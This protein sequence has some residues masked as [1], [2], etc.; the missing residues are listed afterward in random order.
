MKTQE[1]DNSLNLAATSP[2]SLKQRLENHPR[3]TISKKLAAFLIMLST[4]EQYVLYSHWFFLAYCFVAS[5][6]IALSQIILI[7]VLVHWFATLIAGN[8]TS[9]SSPCSM[10]IFNQTM[11]PKKI[12]IPI[13]TWIF[14][15]MIAALIGLEFLKSLSE[16]LKTSLYLTLPFALFS[17]FRWNHQSEG[18]KLRRIRLYLFAL[19]TSLCLA[20]LHSVFSA[21]VGSELPPKI[22]GPVTESGQLVLIIPCLVSLLFLPYERKHEPNT[23]KTIL[24]VYTLFAVCFVSCLL[25][26]WPQI[27]FSAEA[28]SL[29]LATSLLSGLTLLGIVGYTLYYTYTHRS[30][31]LVPG[32]LSYRLFLWAS[33]ALL[34]AAVLINLKRGPWCGIIAALVVLGILHSRKLLVATLSASFFFLFCI[35][36]IRT[37]LFSLV[38]HF[39]IH[40]GRKAMW[41]IGIEL[42]YRFP[43][44]VG[45]ANA[46]YMQTLD[47]TL[48]DL[49]RHMH[50]NLLNI[51][52][53]SGLLGLSAYLW[54]MIVVIGFGFIIWKKLSPP[55]NQQE[56]EARILALGLSSALLGWQVS[57]LVE[58]NFGDGE[59]RLIAFFFMGL[60]LV[61]SS[62]IESP[63]ITKP[64][65][66]GKEQ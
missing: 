46:R 63:G 44:G 8:L 9:H 12:A 51:A 60:L 61:L 37:R 23:Q 64:L 66:A 10:G 11:W 4:P 18:S 34:F 25:L 17:S 54:W 31:L 21:A 6:S 3:Q 16:L 40:G 56:S 45:P 52:V 27:A 62:F 26:V 33:A 28:D 65:Q 48:P 43:L 15:S 5:L 32:Q 29:R 58:Y 59:I 24:S 38:D 20:G 7:V 22:P 55:R 57:G 53:E 39:M 35:T 50:N 19:I 13:L 41:E 30:Q 49:H 14:V 47:P 1:A 42:I 36:P 2:P